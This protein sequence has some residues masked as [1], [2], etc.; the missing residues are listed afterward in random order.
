MADER[1]R[2][3]IAHLQAAFLE[4]IEAAR[5]FLDVAEDVVRDPDLL[6][7][8]ARVADVLRRPARR[9]GPGTDGDPTDPTDDD[10][11]DGGLQRIWVG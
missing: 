2:E 8:V 11:G 5:A 6:A 9:P 10:P 4:L 1:A 7:G 3:G